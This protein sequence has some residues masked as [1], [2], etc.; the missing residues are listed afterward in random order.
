MQL[1]PDRREIIHVQLRCESAH[2]EHR[3][4]YW[5]VF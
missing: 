5:E 1:A 2:R 4:K 3:E